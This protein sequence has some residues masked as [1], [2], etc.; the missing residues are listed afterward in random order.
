VLIKRSQPCAPHPGS[1]GL[2]KELTAPQPAVLEI[3]EPW[4]MQIKFFLIVILGLLVPAI[5]R[6]DSLS[7][8]QIA[9]ELKQDA[10][11]QDVLKPGSTVGSVLLRLRNSRSLTRAITQ[12]YK[13]FPTLLAYQVRPSKSD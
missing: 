9:Q 7:L 8:G 6:A 12:W 11:K 5:A 3:S 4:N 10:V 1:L 13:Y 2:K